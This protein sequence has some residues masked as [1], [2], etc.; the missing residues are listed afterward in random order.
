MDMS[1]KN[2]G[3]LRDLKDLDPRAKTTGFALLAIMFFWII[4]GF[5]AFITSIVC[6][7]RSGTMVEKIIGL[8]LAIFF[9]PF[10]FLFYAFNEGYCR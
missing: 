6:F 5:A 8:L 4:I 9:G 3:H 1:Y 10:Y 7:G 2:Q